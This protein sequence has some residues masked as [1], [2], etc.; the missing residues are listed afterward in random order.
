MYREYIIDIFQGAQLSEMSCMEQVKRGF[1][2]TQ[3]L[4]SALSKKSISH[5]L[6]KIK[7]L[8]NDCAIVVAS[9]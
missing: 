2:A 5:S 9:S 7:Q 4:D 8:S 3:P 1:T 6:P